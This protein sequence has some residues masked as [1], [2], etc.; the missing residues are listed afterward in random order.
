[1]KRWIQFLLLSG[2]LLATGAA[3]GQGTGVSA[4]QVAGMRLVRPASLSFYCTTM[5]TQCQQLDA[6]GDGVIDFDLA[7]EYG[8]A[9]HTVARS[10][11]PATWQVMQDSSNAV[12]SGREDATPL[13]WGALIGPLHSNSLWAPSAILVYINSY[14]G[15]F[16]ESGNWKLDTLTRYVGI[17][18]WQGGAWHYGYLQTRRQ[19]AAIR[20]TIYVTAYAMPAAVAT[21]TAS[22]QLAEIGLYPNPTNDRLTISLPA[23]TPASAELL[24]LTGRLHKKVSLSGGPNLLN[25]VGLPAGIYLLQ[26]STAEGILIR[27]ITKQ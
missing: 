17:R 2:L 3:A 16:Y 8:A 1:M 6:D 18:H 22:P 21:A 10:L 20:S 13:P 15:R 11:S 26:V 25:L 4:G 12:S 23:A 9:I 5:N 24:D 14:S 7:L 27:R 19:V